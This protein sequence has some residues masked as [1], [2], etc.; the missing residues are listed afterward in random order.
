M[1]AKIVSFRRGKHTYKPRHFILEIENVTT[2]EEAK[3]F[4]NKQVEWKNPLGKG[5]VIKGKITA[6]HGNKGLVRAI[7]E[8]GLPG[9]AINT[10][11]EI[12]ES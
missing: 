2:K 6:L 5:K 11:A 8:K 7:F 9:Q 4:I 12:K 1:K 10:E 3:K